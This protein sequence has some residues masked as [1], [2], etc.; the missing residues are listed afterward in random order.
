MRNQSQ[1]TMFEFVKK[2]I[3]DVIHMKIK[4]L[5]MEMNEFLDTKLAK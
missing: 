5:H 4:D 2:N 3:E 1:G